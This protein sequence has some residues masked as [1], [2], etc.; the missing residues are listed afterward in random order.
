[1]V[2][3]D[4]WNSWCGLERM[5]SGQVAGLK[6]WGGSCC[7]T[8]GV[9]E[10][11]QGRSSDARSGSSRVETRTCD[12]EDVGPDVA[13][14]EHC[15]TRVLSRKQGEVTT[16]ASCGGH[17]RGSQCCVRW[18]VGCGRL[19]CF[20]A[21]RITLFEKTH[22]EGSLPPSQPAPRQAEHRS[23][24]YGAVPSRDSLAFLLFPSW[25]LRS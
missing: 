11:S 20:P 25:M 2:R 10:M 19:S 22:L 4:S 3:G 23:L 15:P 6:A 18:A 21:M 16:G 7:W 12:A 24:S 13:G 1:M 9:Q 8:T 5:D 17:G 14:W